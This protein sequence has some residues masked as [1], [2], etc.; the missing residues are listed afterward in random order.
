V[1]GRAAR[2]PD[3]AE[4]TDAIPTALA[5]A[6]FSYLPNVLGAIVIAILG[7]LCARVVARTVL[8]HAVNA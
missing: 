6:V 3:G 4:R 8:I 5:L 2:H 7:D 1:D